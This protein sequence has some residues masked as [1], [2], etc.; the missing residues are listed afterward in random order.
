[1]NYAV[2]ENGSRNEMQL[3]ELP[4]INLF[5]NWGTVAVGCGRQ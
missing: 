4:T 1:M 3:T 5:P 2:D